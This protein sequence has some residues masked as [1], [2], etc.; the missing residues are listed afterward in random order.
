MK[1]ILKEIVL[2]T[3]IL[4][5]FIYSL[6]NNTLITEKIIYSTNIWLTKIVPTLFPTF[7]IVDLISNSKI[8]YYIS[9]YLHINYIYIL[10][11]ISGSPSNAYL[12]SNY[13]NQDLTKLLATT[14]YTSFIFT[15]NY[16]LLI[17]NK[18]ISIILIILNILSTIILIKL[19]KPSK[20]NFKVSK[21]KI[22]LP[23]S[24]TKSIN[25][26]ISILGSIIF[27]NILPI[28]SIDNIYI[29]SFLL[30][31]T[32]ITT[33]LTNLS[34]TSLPIY[35]KLLF[36]II[37]ISTCGFCIE[38]QIKSIISDTSINYNKYLLYRLI[39]LLLYISLS[40]ITFL[41]IKI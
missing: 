22:N 33:S 29:K 20:L 8:P 23:N 16:L 13:N 41:V 25:S 21:N 17:F 3:I 19:I 14:K 4:L 32:E 35:I 15:Y 7:I 28:S 12:L 36:T 5:L 37:S 1:N 11:I 31:I 26:L 24:I 27:F 10:S 6:T 30:S 9:K 34:V 18:K 38:T 2:F 39:H 40:I